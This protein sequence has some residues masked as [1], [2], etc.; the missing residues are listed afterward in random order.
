MY[1]YLYAVGRYK[2]HMPG[3]HVVDISRSR[4]GDLEKLFSIL[5]IV[6]RDEL[7]NTDISLLL[8]DHRLSFSNTPGVTI[9]EWLTSQASTPLRTAKIKPGKDPFYVKLERIFSNGYFHYPGDINL[10]KDRQAELFADSAPDVLIKH[11]KYVA[12]VD[13]RKLNDY[14]LFTLNGVFYRGFGRSDGLYLLGAGLDYIGHKQD[15]RAGALNFEKLG[16]ITTIPITTANLIEQD[17]PGPKRY[18]VKVTETSLDNKTVWIVINGQLVVDS[19]MLHR[20]SD[21][22]MAINPIA[23][24]PMNHYQVF[25]HY[26]RTPVL[27]DMTKFDRY[28]KEALLM[29]NSFL[30]VIDNPTLGVETVPLATHLFPNV[31]HTEERFQHPVVLDNG[32]FPVPYMKSY[33]IGQRLLNFDLRIHR[34]YPVQTNGTLNGQAVNDQY[35]NQGDP[36][37]LPKGF[38]FKI[39]GVKFEAV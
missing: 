12:G 28:K 6:A 38:F 10:T 25:K 8:D 35:V 30:V 17:S 34:K 9:Q 13:Y 33:G 24:D 16:K 31:L 15:L 3:F 32:L 7:F 21:N 14:S 22:H 23:F 18:R 37:E 29:H 20:V 1:K 5:Y 11:Y 27:K 2:G 36:G 39:H 19:E 4:V 26:C